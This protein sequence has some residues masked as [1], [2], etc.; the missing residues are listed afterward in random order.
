MV[1][2]NDYRNGVIF[3]PYNENHLKIIL[4]V[5]N[6]ANIIY[7]GCDKNLE[8]PELL[9]QFKFVVIGLNY[10]KVGTETDLATKIHDF[11]YKVA[12]SVINPVPEN[13]IEK[14]NELIDMGFDY[15]YVDS[16]PYSA[17]KTKME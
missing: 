12:S 10:L 1:C 15:I 7:V 9:K 2:K 13:P 4:E 5:S 6:E 8:I 17:I 11:G 16:I 14:L 3:E